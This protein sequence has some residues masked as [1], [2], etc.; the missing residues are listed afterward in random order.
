[1]DRGRGQGGKGRK[2]GGRRCSL[3]NVLDPLSIRLILEYT[4]RYATVAPS[5]PA[6]VVAGP[7]TFCSLKLTPLCLSSASSPFV[8][9]AAP[10][11]GPSLSSLQALSASMVITFSPCSLANLKHASRDA[12]SP[13]GE[14][15]STSSQRRA[16]AGK[17]AARARSGSATKRRVCQCQRNA[18][19]VKFSLWDR[20][21]S[22]TLASVW[23]ILTLTPPSV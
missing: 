11:R 21:Y 15:G 8:G 3:K 22:P 6:V 7:T 20:D 14:S 23:P 1:M 17:P 18:H 16:E 2:Q 13:V 12:M 5:T 10:A 9:A 4:F 19:E